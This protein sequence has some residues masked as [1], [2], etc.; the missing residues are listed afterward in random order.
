[1]SKRNMSLDIFTTYVRTES[2]HEKLNFLVT[3][4][5]KE[6][7]VRCKNNGLNNRTFLFFFY[8]EH[9]LCV[10]RETRHATVQRGSA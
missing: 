5:R 1:M 2:F 3:Y 7:K 8:M 6:H 4:V 9:K 10:C